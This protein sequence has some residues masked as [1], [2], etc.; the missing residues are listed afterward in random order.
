M[1]KSVHVLHEGRSLCGCEWP[2]G[3]WV[4]L[5]DVWGKWSRK[6]IRLMSYDICPE[7]DR[8]AREGE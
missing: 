3:M 4:S 1:K 7:C 5:R 2:H 8:I 6:Q